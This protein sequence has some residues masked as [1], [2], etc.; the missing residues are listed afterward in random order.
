M[1]CMAVD[2]IKKEIDKLSAEERREISIYLTKIRLE[3]DGQFWERVRHR[4]DDK[5]PSRWVSIDDIK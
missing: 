3:N 2:E 4:T 5:D 1:H